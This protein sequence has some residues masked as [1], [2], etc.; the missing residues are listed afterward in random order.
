MAR[1][2]AGELGRTEGERQGQKKALRNPPH[3]CH[4]LSLPR[5]PTPGYSLS[6]QTLPAS[7]SYPM[8]A[9]SSITQA[10]RRQLSPST[11]LRSKAYSTGVPHGVSRPHD[12][13]EARAEGTAFMEAEGWDVKSLHEQ[14]IV[15]SPSCGSCWPA[16]TRSAGLGRPR[17][18]SLGPSASCPCAQPGLVE[19]LVCARQQCEVH[20]LLRDGED[21][22]RQVALAGAP[23]GVGEV[24]GPGQAWGGWSD[25]WAYLG[26]VQG[27]LRGGERTREA[28]S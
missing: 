22:F 4:A 5:I 28:R 9:F 7:S 21:G 13:N 12:Y 3:F 14:P 16:L 25:P 17:V 2:L 19:Q 11:L 18:S 10:A 24:A 1:E 20:Y 8:P 15:R 6:R 26:A 27:G 23:P